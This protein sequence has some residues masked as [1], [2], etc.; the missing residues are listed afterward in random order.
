[1][2]RTLMPYWTKLNFKTTRKRGGD[3]IIL[4]N[5][6]LENELKKTKKPKKQE[7]IAF[8]LPVTLSDFFQW[9]T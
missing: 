3:Q 2:K 5:S 1:M 7:A 8:N 4:H 6:V 9:N